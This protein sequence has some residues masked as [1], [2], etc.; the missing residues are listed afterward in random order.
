MPN[1][2]VDLVIMQREPAKR[3]YFLCDGNVA[4]GKVAV[5]DDFTEN[6]ARKAL[7][8][9]RVLTVKADITKFFGLYSNY[10]NTV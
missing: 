4:F 7:A 5:H 3:T 1:G 9:A 6:I 2:Q 10:L 8:T